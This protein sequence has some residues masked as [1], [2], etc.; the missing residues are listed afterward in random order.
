VTIFL[1]VLAALGQV[2]GIA[3]AVLG[4]LLSRWQTE[5]MLRTQAQIARDAEREKEDRAEKRARVDAGHAVITEVEGFV[6]LH[7]V[8]GNAWE[9]E[10][11]NLRIQVSAIALR[12]VRAFEDRSLYKLVEDLLVA[13]ASWAIGNAEGKTLPTHVNKMSDE[14]REDLLARLE[15]MNRPTVDAKQ[16]PPP[17]PK[18]LEE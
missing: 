3:G 7:V 10:P 11:S 9:R 6:A 15:E 16:P 8:R 2:F 12:A 18:R 5:S 13:S 17:A 14:L 4:Q 1:A